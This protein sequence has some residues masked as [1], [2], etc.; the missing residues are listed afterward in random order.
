MT[1]PFISAM[2]SLFIV[3]FIYTQLG[4]AIFGGKINIYSTRDDDAVPGLYY[5]LNFNSFGSGMITM[6]HMMIVNNW[7]E[8][9]KMYS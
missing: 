6:Y 4:M 8:T 5:L 2:I 3:F 9:V 1:G 7:Y